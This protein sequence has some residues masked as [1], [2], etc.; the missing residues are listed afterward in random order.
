MGQ[1]YVRNNQ[2]GGAK[3]VQSDRARAGYQQITHDQHKK[4]LKSPSGTRRAPDG[5]HSVPAPRHPNEQK[6]LAFRASRRRTK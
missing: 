4:L 3:M 2:F 1:W 6:V 5:R